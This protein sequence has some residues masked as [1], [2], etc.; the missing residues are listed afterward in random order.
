MTVPRIIPVVT[1]NTE[2]C[3]INMVDR[4]M[5]K[6]SIPEAIRIP[7]LFL[8]PALLITAKCAPMELYTWMLGH[9]LVGVSIFHRK[10][11]ACV[12]ILSR[13]ITAGLK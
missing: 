1:S 12:K 8:N 4:M 2:C 11:T 5:E 9:K 6:A 3:L 10:D 13:G 7:F